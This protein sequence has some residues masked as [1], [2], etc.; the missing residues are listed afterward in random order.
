MARS[1][2]AERAGFGPKLSPQNGYHSAS[3]METR[4][5]DGVAFSHWGS[6]L[7]MDSRSHLPR[8]ADILLI[9][10]C[11]VFC[12][13]PWMWQRMRNLTRLHNP[14]PISGNCSARRNRLVPQISQCRARSFGCDAQVLMRSLHVVGPVVGCIYRTV[15]KARLASQPGPSNKLCA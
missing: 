4:T 5:S 9:H 12:I 7:P 13:V 15:C 1:S 10:R 3:R 11:Y 2:L 14:A 6:N 8:M